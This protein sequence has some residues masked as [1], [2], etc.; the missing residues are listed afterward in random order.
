M[1]CVFFIGYTHYWLTG[2]RRHLYSN[3][4]FQWRMSSFRVPMISQ[5]RHERISHDEVLKWKCF[6]HQWS[7]VHDDVIKWKLFPR[8]WPALLVAGEFPA[9]RPVTRS[10]DVYFVNWW[11][12]TQS[13]SLWRHC[14]GE[15]YT[16]HNRPL[17][18]S[19][20]VS[21]AVGPDKLLNEQSGD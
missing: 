3:S 14:N 21:F 15:E 16:G 4:C 10:F 17:I 5:V 9:Q 12:E 1:H 11:F 2:L 20:I 8:Y 7:F 18:E 13:C 6:P 19:L